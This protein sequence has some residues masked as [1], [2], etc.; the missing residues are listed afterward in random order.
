ME[1]M[2]SAAAIHAFVLPTDFSSDP[3]ITTLPLSHPVLDFTIL[4]SSQL[5]VSY[6]PAFNVFTHNQTGQA[7]AKGKAAETTTTAEQSAELS[8]FVTLVSVGSGASVRRIYITVGNAVTD[9]SAR[10]HLISSPH[11]RPEPPL[12]SFERRPP[13]NAICPTALP[14]PLPPP[15]LAGLRRRRRT[16]R[17][18]RTCRRPFNLRP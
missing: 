4:P 13:Q 8:N 17:I 9:I 14:Q 5:L 3:Q 15:S 6:D 1:L 16:S 12:P 11:F 2:D 7:P 18:K 10:E